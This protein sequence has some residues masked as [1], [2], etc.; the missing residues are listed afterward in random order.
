MGGRSFQM[1]DVAA[2]TARPPK[3]GC[4]TRGGAKKVDLEERR[5]CR[6]RWD[7]AVISSEEGYS[8]TM[9]LWKRKASVQDVSRSAGRPKAHRRLKVKT[10]DYGKKD[11][12]LTYLSI[13]LFGNESTD[14]TKISDLR[15]TQ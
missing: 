6:P 2:P 13:D 7:E 14:Q 10:K 4:R 1:R 3:V 9:F 12:Q 15:V 5:F 11:C 8:G